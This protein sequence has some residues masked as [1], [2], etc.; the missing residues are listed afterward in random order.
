MTRVGIMETAIRDGH[1]SLLA[2]RMR[3]EDMIPVLEQMDEIGYHSIECWGG[4]TFDTSMR[5]L[6]EDPWE[7]LREIK[8]RLKKTPTQMLLRGQNVVG[9]RHYADDVVYEFCDRSVQNGMDIF[10]IFDALNDTRNLET[11]FKAVKKAGGHVQGTICYTTSP[12]HT[13]ETNA[14]LADE[15]VAMGAD[16]LCIKDMAGLLSPMMAKAL[17]SRLKKDHPGMLVQMHCH[18]TS[19]YSEMAYLMGVQA[20]ADVIDCAISPLAGGTS[21]PATETLVAALAEDPE[22]AT[23]LDLEKLGDLAAYFKDVRR[24]YWKFES[25]LLGIDAG[26]LAHQIPGGMISNLVGQLREQG[27]EHKWPEVVKENA[28]VREDLGFPPLVTPSSQIVG[29]QAV[30]NVLTGQR[31][32]TVTKETK[33][34]AKGMYGKTPAPI[35]AEVLKTIL[36]D[37]QPITHRPADELQPEMEAAKTEAGD[38]VKAPEDV[39]SYLM[40]PQP[41][42]EFLEWRNSGGGP[43]R[44]LVAA[45]I[46]ALF[47]KDQPARSATPTEIVVT[48]NGAANT[49]RDFGRIRQLR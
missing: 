28:R 34:L 19:G 16:S 15:L 29:S 24:R 37:E 3:T 27:A 43:E 21:Q 22:H 31:Y 44:E 38:L 12:I 45:V 10:R 39:L 7:R 40:F 46:G 30:L 32:A 20:G 5:F 6:K 2:T 42:K 36:G 9:Y 25:N 47:V 14:K 26:V 35:S 8:K 23:G 1:Q 17:V 18:D 41:A 33:N 11:A 49:W 4:A 48:G 13:V